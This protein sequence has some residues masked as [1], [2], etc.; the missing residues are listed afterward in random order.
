MGRREQ[1]KDP[2]AASGAASVTSVRLP[3]ISLF[4]SWVGRFFSS[5]KP[6]DEQ[7]NGLY[8]L[9][10]LYYLICPTCTGMVFHR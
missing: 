9:A 10:G 2:A 1:A 7:A 3:M 5:S 4:S 6:E 8:V